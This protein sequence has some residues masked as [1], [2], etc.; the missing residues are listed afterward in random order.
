MID[1]SGDY[2]NTLWVT[3]IIF[4]FTY[5][6]ISVSG[7]GK[8]KI[9]RSMAAALG[10][11][12]VVVL[13]IVAI[14]DIPEY[15]NFNVLFL[16]L[17]MMMLVAGLEFSGFFRIVSDHLMKWSGDKARLLAYIMI[18]CA[19]LSAVALNDAVVLIFTP[20]VIKCC[21]RSNSN[22]IPYLI[23]VM[24]SSNIGSLATAV[25]NPHNAYIASIA[26]IPFIDFSLYTLPIALVCLPVAFLIIY[27]IFRRNLTSDRTFDDTGAEQEIDR[28]RLHL[29]MTILLGA[30]VGFALSSAIDVQTSVIAMIA[31]TLALIVVMTKAPK[32]IIWV[33]KK[34]NWKIIIFFIGLFILMGAVEVSGLLDHIA[35][36][37]P[38]FEDGGTPSVLGVTTFTAILSNLVSNVPAVML[39]GNLLPADNLALW[40]ALAASS[41]L[42][43]NTTLIASAANVIVAE[44]SESDGVSFNFWKFALIGIP[45]T[46]ITLLVSVGMIMLIF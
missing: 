6:L 34:I 2:V 39:I 15:L 45:V 3:A 36:I 10:G 37:F 11:I 7:H 29:V 26:D 1:C 9:S 16:L 4:V 46:V 35:S 43:G 17:G 30:L 25:G 40:F 27:A 5:A 28:V 21:K 44:R 38:G 22:P 8:I 42:A 31:G 14:T 41:T 24:F 32:N 19:V 12:L 20:I 18:M 13:G 23:G 33:A